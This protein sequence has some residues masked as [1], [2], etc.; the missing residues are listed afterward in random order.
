MSL[1][2]REVDAFD[3]I[4]KNDQGE[5]VAAD[6]SLSMLPTGKD[7]VT[8]RQLSDRE[9]SAEIRR[10]NPDGTDWKIVYDTPENPSTYFLAARAHGYFGMSTQAVIIPLHQ[11][12]AYLRGII[13][14]PP[15]PRSDHMFDNKAQA[16]DW[17]KTLTPSIEAEFARDRGLLLPS[18]ARVTGE[19]GMQSLSTLRERVNPF[20]Q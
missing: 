13:A 6:G 7:V 11:L 20:R 9:V 4:G 3:S 1:D 14:V 18:H 8:I 12:E 10:T 2:F 17:L 16:F 5:E 15:K 19:A